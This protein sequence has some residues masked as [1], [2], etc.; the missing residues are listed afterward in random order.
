MRANTIK[1]TTLY[2]YRPLLPNRLSHTPADTGDFDEIK[3]NRSKQ[4]TANALS[5]IALKPLSRKRWHT[6]AIDLTVNQNVATRK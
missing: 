1:T 3:G 2:S 4:Q 6:S 5:S